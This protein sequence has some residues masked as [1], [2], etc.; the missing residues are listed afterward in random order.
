[1]TDP[2]KFGP[3]WLRNMSNDMG[4]SSSG[5][6]GGPNS[7]A[8]V[9]GGTGGIGG[10]NINSNNYSY[11]AASNTSST[12]LSGSSNN[13]G[14]NNFNNSNN[15]SSHLSNSVSP[16][17]QLA[18]FRYGREEML[19]LFDKSIRIPEIL[20]KFKKLFIEKIQSPLALSPS[21]EDE[22][23]SS[24][25]CFFFKRTFIIFYNS[26]AQCGQLEIR[27]LRLE[28][29]VVALEVVRLIGVGVVVEDL[30]I[31]PSDF[32]DLVQCMMKMLGEEV[33]GYGSKYLIQSFF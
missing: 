32:N 13:I 23:V 28:L 29:Q 18:E 7:V 22:M 6:S 31:R 2:M 4:T 12:T 19:S 27:H 14:V 17:Y 24:Y 26:H 16:R 9:I 11:S 20:P 30:I 8:S 10:G 1:M 3:E 33:P 25:F 5:G 15:N 21:T